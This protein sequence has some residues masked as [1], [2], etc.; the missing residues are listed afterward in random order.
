MDTSKKP[1]AHKIKVR[2]VPTESSP[3]RGHQVQSRVRYP[4]FCHGC[5]CPCPCPCCVGGFGETNKTSFNN[6]VGI[7]TQLAAMVRHW[8]LPPHSTQNT[9]PVWY[10]CQGKHPSQARKMPAPSRLYTRGGCFSQIPSLLE[11]ALQ[12]S[13]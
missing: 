2:I 7:I 11:P 13:L 6:I 8:S 12:L 1:K 9:A 4:L 10:H 3:C 5:P